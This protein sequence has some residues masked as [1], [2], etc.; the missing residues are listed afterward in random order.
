MVMA[1]PKE[2]RKVA[3]GTVFPAALTCFVTGVTEPLEFTFLFLAPALFFGFHA[4][5]CALSFL[6]ANVLSVHIGMAF[7][8]GFL[9]LVVYGMVPVM[10]GT[11]F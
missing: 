10:K 5:M 6:M 2:N 3:L 4:F 1:A 9:D 8:G 7:S 11:N